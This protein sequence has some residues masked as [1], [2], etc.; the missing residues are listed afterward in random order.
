[1]SQMETAVQ[2]VEEY[3][4]DLE[5]QY[6]I[7]DALEVLESMPSK[8]AAAVHLDDAWAR[9]KRCG[10]LGVEFDTHGLE[11]TFEIVDACFDVLEEGGWMIADCD[12]WLLPR[13]IDYIR[14]THGDV[15]AS[16][17]GGGYRKIG[18]VTYVT[19]DG[20]VDRRPP[21]HYFRNGGYPVV[22]AHRGKTDRQS[23]AAARQLAPKVSYDVDWGTAKPIDPY[24]NWLEGLV[25]AD[26]RIVVPCAGTAPSALAIERLYGED[27]RYVCIDTEEAAYEA[28]C[29]R[30]PSQ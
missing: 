3:D 26:D 17:E 6:V 13:L 8:S 1:M 16:Y 23:L 20:T 30:R 25:D 22:F 4:E 28:F 2:R 21:G 11:T 27:A 15:A 24:E 5:R 29:R 19:D 7:G 10:N 12:D 9:P 18:D 14:E